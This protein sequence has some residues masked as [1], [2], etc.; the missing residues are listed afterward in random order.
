MGKRLNGEAGDGP[1]DGARK[2]YG[3]ESFPTW[4]A[5]VGAPA[6]AKWERFLKKHRPRKTPPTASGNADRMAGNIINAY[7]Q[8][9]GPTP[10]SEVN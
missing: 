5:R 3:Q 7:L 6:L 8:R 2:C 10:F 9:A 4:R 1:G